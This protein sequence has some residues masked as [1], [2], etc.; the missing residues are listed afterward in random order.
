[1]I[2]SCSRNLLILSIFLG[3]S[4]TT[5]QTMASALENYLTPEQIEMLGVET[6]NDDYSPKKK[7][8]R[9]KVSA[10]VYELDKIVIDKIKDSLYKLVSDDELENVAFQTSL[11]KIRTIAYEK[12]FLKKLASYGQANRI[13]DANKSH[14]AKIWKDAINNLYDEKNNDVIDE[15]MKAL[16]IDC[17]S[18]DDFSAL[19]ESAE[20]TTYKTTLLNILIRRTHSKELAF[21]VQTLIENG[22]DKN[23]HKEFSVSPKMQNQTEYPLRVVLDKVSDVRLRNQILKVLL[24][25]NVVY[26]YNNI[27]DDKENE[28]LKP[29]KH[30]LELEGNKNFVLE[31][32]LEKQD[33]S[34]FEMVLSY[35]EKSNIFVI[36]DYEDEISQIKDQIYSP[37]LEKILSKMSKLRQKAV[38]TNRH[39]DQSDNIKEFFES[40]YLASHMSKDNHDA[41]FGE[42]FRRRLEVDFSNLFDQISKQIDAYRTA[43]EIHGAEF[44]DIAIE[45][46]MW[47]NFRNRIAS[48]LNLYALSASNKGERS[49]VIRLIR[50]TNIYNEGRMVNSDDLLFKELHVYGGKDIIFKRTNKYGWTPLMYAMVQ[51]QSEGIQLYLRQAPHE[52]TQTD[53]VD[54][55]ILHLAFPLPEQH[56]ID[57]NAQAERNVLQLVGAEAV[58]QGVKEKTE[59]SIKAVITERSIDKKDKVKALKQLSASNYTPV[60]LAAAMGY[61]DI[62]EYLVSYLKGEGEWNRDDHSHLDTHVEE[63]V[64]AG[65]KNYLEMKS[66]DLSSEEVE[67]IEK[68]ID[69]RQ[70]D[71]DKMIEE[72]IDEIYDSES[73]IARQYLEQ[74]MSPAKKILDEYEDQKG[75]KRA[76]APYL[77]A[78]NASFNEML[79]PPY[80]TVKVWKTRM[81]EESIPRR[82]LKIPEV[83]QP[84]KKK[85]YKFGK[86]KQPE[87]EY[88]TVYDKKQTEEPYQDDEHKESPLAGMKTARSVVKSSY[89]G[90]V[91]K[92]VTTRYLRHHTSP[93]LL[94]FDV[95]YKGLTENETK[96]F[97]KEKF[98]QT[99]ELRMQEVIRETLRE[100]DRLREEELEYDASNNRFDTMDQR[101]RFQDNLGIFAEEADGDYDSESDDI[102]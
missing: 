1:M 82:V 38:T 54:N 81:V 94:S 102:I 39:S 34:T 91:V 58:K 19:E 41:R 98:N 63:I 27:L 24:N 92:F 3:F 26:A 17:D 64:V 11:K 95:V 32:L 51:K 23:L 76:R 42:S 72:S 53:G 4:A 69:L 15:D 5:N 79:N 7:K 87:P 49:N 25:D 96:D 37:V 84:V 57:E 33:F 80:I 62:Y 56:F 78:F 89:L 44:K 21:K 101:N 22:A 59:E 45:W 36:A 85:W 28:G 77:T 61:V 68:D 100:S 67:T 10:S 13:E 66:D 9:P 50:Y 60:S 70:K 55:N 18:D 43:T 71:I 35:L 83:E 16:G 30:S 74:I 73:H 40:R 48:H 8:E 90:Q 93:R 99:V 88:I 12:F 29:V 86:K 65:L 52:I 47:A 20:P 46:A 2:T 75:T 6:Q 97:F 31:N 14:F